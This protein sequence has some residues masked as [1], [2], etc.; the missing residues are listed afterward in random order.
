MVSHTLFPRVTLPFR[1]IYAQL[2]K[3]TR[4][5]SPFLSLSLFFLPL[6]LHSWL[7]LFNSLFSINTQQNRFLQHWSMFCF[8]MQII[9]AN[10]LS[11]ICL[12]NRD[13][14]SMYVPTITF[15]TVSD[16]FFAWSLFRYNSQSVWSIVVCETTGGNVDGTISIWFCF[17]L[18]LY[19][20]YQLSGVLRV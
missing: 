18:I 1:K 17:S 12:K 4:F 8:H 3:A 2:S 15:S 20:R 6:M 14:W 10:N 11:E 13:S 5:L 9:S 16:S 7:S 19:Q